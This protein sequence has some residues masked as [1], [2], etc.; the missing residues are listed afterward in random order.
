VLNLKLYLIGRPAL[1]TAAVLTMGVAAVAATSAPVRARREVQTLRSVAALPPH[2]TGRFGDPA[3]FQQ[4]PD[5]QY[6]VVDRRGHTVSRIDAAMT[7]VTP[8]VAI[9]HELGRI[10]L[11]FGFDLGEGEFAVADAPAGAARVQVFTTSGSRLAAFT[12]ASRPAARVALDGLV[13]N[14]PGS[15][16]FTARRTILLSQPETGA[17]IT[18]YDLR[19]AALRSIG[20]LRTTPHDADPQLRLA[21]NAGLPIPAPD[22]MYF[23]FQTGEPRFRKYDA[24]GQLVFERAIQ[25]RELDALLQMQP[26]VW[27]G[28][29]DAARDGGIPVVRPVV[30]AAALDPRGQLWISFTQPYTYVYDS[31]GEKVRTVQ[32]TAAGVLMPTSLFFAHDGRL[33][34][35]PGC[36]L[37]R[38]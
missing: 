38:P 20:A 26:T 5:G 32:F 35:T 13:L 29:S 12:L 28:R 2:V 31:D 19:G 18:E 4:T 21:F 10:L 15:M 3:A 22:G 8:L 16:R 9:G 30:R 7:S 25:G 11:P 36:Y 17:L 1:Q 14:G 37:F 24:S 23:V 33:L 27:P 34:V 6:F